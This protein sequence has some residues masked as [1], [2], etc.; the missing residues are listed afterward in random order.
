MTTNHVDV[1]HLRHSVKCLPSHLK[2]EHEHFTKEKEDALRKAKSVDDVFFT[3]DGYWDFLNYS[4]LQHII[5]RHASD[6]IK[7]EMERYAEK[8]VSFRKKTSLRGFSKAYKRKPK[9]AD[10]KFKKLVSEHNFDLSTATLEDVEQ[11]RN[12]ICSELSLFTFSLQ[13]AALTT[14]S[15][16]IT[17]LVPQ[18]LVAHIQKAITLSSQTMRKHHVSQ[19]TVDGF[20]TYD[21]NAGSCMCSPTATIFSIQRVAWSNCALIV[22][23][24]LSEHA[25][26]Q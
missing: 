8:I 19:L 3:A 4:L 25:L 1:R 10:E 18:S 11:F 16:V 6:E 13:L 23:S 20:I 2:S 17:W 24:Y 12:D 22:L 15:L 14:G 9:K 7:K 26:G 21:G 5:D